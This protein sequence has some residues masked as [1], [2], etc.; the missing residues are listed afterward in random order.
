MKI[1]CRAA[2]SIRSIDFFTLLVLTLVH[3]NPE[4]TKFAF[5]LECSEK[6]HLENMPQTLNYTLK[7]EPHCTLLVKTGNRGV[8]EN[9]KSDGLSVEKL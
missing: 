2:Q 7:T 5:G 6:K 9:L 4:A 8:L 1:A 3:H